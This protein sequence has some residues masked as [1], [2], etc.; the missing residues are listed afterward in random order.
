VVRAA[1]DAKSTSTAAQP[2][3]ADPAKAD[4]KTD[5]KTG[6]KADAKA[7]ASAAAK[8]AVTPPDDQEKAPPPSSADK[9]PSPQR[10]TPSEQVRADFDVS[11]PVD[12]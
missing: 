11:F 2:A 9:G 12:I 8:P 5:A 7:D 10:F 6:A 1:K 4:A 3:K